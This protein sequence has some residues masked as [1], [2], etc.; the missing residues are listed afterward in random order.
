MVTS[1]TPLRISFVGGGT[2]VPWFYQKHGGEVISTAID[3]FMTVKVGAR[4]RG[5]EG[6]S[7]NPIVRECLR[8]VGIDGGV[9]IE[10]ESEVPAGTGLGSSSAL[11]VG[12]LNALLAYKTEMT[13]Y[14]EFIAE[15]ACMIEIGMLGNPI[16]KQ[17]QYAATYGG[18]R[19][20]KFHKDG[21]VEL[22]N[23]KGG[24]WANLE[25][26]LML[27][28]TRIERG[29]DTATT[30][31][32]FSNHDED[33]L[34]E[35]K[36]LVPRFDYAWFHDDVGRVGGLLHENWRLKSQLNDSISNG[37]LDKIYQLAL[38]AGALGGKLL[39]AG[40]GGHFLFY[41][42][43]EQQE[44]VKAALD[45]LAVHVEFKF[46]AQGTRLI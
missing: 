2:D 26:Q 12:L 13:P 4:E 20:Y 43:P 32:L 37:P 1:K 28:R 41:V 40:G 44:A 45:G 31:A 27:F 3:K 10:I 46:E 5:S 9:S 15:A 8:K 36:A 6:A 34:K 35:I 11:T 30:T 29:A 14:K 17:D 22:S 23:W 24:S 19:H 42:R 39:G 33:K 18:V 38:D 21:S 16:G 7:K 25:G